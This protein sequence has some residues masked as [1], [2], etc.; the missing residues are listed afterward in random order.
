MRVVVFPDLIWKCVSPNLNFSLQKKKKG[1]LVHMKL[2]Y[3][4]NSTL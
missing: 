2:K 3:L 1:G 4:Q